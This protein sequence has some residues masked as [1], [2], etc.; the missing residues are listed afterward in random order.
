[1]KKFSLNDPR[2]VVNSPKFGNDVMPGVDRAIFCKLDFFCCIFNNVSLS[3]V[4][5]DFLKLSV[6]PSD[7]FNTIS[8]RYVGMSSS[9]LWSY[10]SVNIS[11]PRDKFFM[12]NV[13]PDDGYARIANVKFDSIRLEISGKGLD[14][15]R[16]KGLDVDTEFRVL[17]LCDPDAG[18]TYKPLWHVTRADFAFDFVNYAGDFLQK[19][20]D[21]VTPLCVNS[22]RPSVPLCSGGRPI[23]VSPRHGEHTLYLGSPSSDALLR[24]YDKKFECERKGNLHQFIDAFNVGAVRSFIRVEWQTRNDIAQRYLHSS[25]DWVSILKE[26]FRRYAFYDRD[27]RAPAEFWLN[28]FNWSLIPDIIQNENFV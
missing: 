6:A 25:S 18:D 17:P 9:Y 12:A 16:S 22:A 3:F 5:N 26:I 10:N 14:F 27:T 7:I 15:L 28:L 24:I 19:C 21:W 13:S 20:L 2:L 1:M 11:I 23:T 4:L 8:Y